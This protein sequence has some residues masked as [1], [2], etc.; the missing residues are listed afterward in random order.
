MCAI[1]IVTSVYYTFY[2]VVP[3][4]YIIRDV[5]IVVCLFL[6]SL[7]VKSAKLNNYF[8][9]VIINPYVDKHP[10]QQPMG[11]KLTDVKAMLKVVST[12]FLTVSTISAGD[13]SHGWLCIK[14]TYFTMN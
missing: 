2:V 7:H 3:K 9:G 4:M 5:L 12:N 10:S 8:T 11:Y 14:M 6:R 1:K 13:A